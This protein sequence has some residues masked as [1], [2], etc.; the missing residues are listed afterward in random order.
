MGYIKNPYNP[1][2]HN[3]HSIRLKG[4]D[5]SRPGLY[6]ITICV[7]DR[8]CILSEINMRSV[9]LTNFGKIVE[10][11]WVQL[12]QRF[13]NVMLDT[14]VIMPNHLHGI[15]IV[16]DCDNDGKVWRRGAV[17]AP[18]RQNMPGQLYGSHPTLGKII[19]YFKYQSTKFVNQ[20]QNTPGIKFWQRNYYEHI[21]R[22]ES[23]LIQIR[24]YIKDNP[25]QWLDDE[26][27]PINI[28]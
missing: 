3:R 28:K 6:F 13:N 23:E 21:I 25:R 17:T 27:N 20:L 15:I 12:P 4:Y 14:Y 26:N 8:E 24:R 16:N 2:K 7:R 18:L 19:A 22:D 1:N 10:K 9:I 11:F 5:Y